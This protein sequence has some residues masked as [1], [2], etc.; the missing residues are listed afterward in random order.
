MKRASSSTK[1]HRTVAGEMR[2]ADCKCS[3]TVSYTSPSEEGPLIP[4]I[5]SRQ[6]I[7]P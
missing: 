5:P 6:D 7:A 1:G 4:P 3:D 2:R